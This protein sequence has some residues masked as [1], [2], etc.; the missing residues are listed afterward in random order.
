MKKKA[1]AKPPPSPE[2]AWIQLV[3][4][5]AL[6]GVPILED[7]KFDGIPFCCRSSPNPDDLQPP[8]RVRVP[9]L[10]WFCF[11]FQHILKL[12]LH[13]RSYCMVRLTSTG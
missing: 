9:R 11:K 12:D 13:F 4:P 5:L 1:F 2:V 3:E 6:V 7:K 10:S 8:T